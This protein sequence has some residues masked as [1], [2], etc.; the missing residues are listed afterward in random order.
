MFFKRLF[1]LGQDD[2][3]DPT[4]GQTYSAQ[5]AAQDSVV[6]EA[7]RSGRK[8]NA[9]KRYRELTGV[10]LKEAKEAIDEL[11]ANPSTTTFTSTSND[12]SPV[13]DP[14][15]DPEFMRYL[16]QNKKI[17]AVKRYREL[18]NVTLKEAKEAVERLM[19]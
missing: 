4:A 12:T 5:A 15:H 1:G 9:I 14:V 8:I 17:N 18:T 13:T 3:T 6:Q 10:G 7:I 2:N 16:Q 19:K 11:I